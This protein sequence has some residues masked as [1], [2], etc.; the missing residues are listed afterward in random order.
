LD[1]VESLPNR[2]GTIVTPGLPQIFQQASQMR[3]EIHTHVRD[4]AKASEHTRQL[5]ARI[6]SLEE[7]L[8]QATELAIEAQ[9]AVEFVANSEKGST[10]PESVDDADALRKAKVTLRLQDAKIHGLEAMARKASA[11]CEALEREKAEWLRERA[12]M[13]KRVAEMEARMLESVADAKGESE[14][15]GANSTNQEHGSTEPTLTVEE[16]AYSGESAERALASTPATTTSAAM[17]PISTQSRSWASSPLSVDTSNM[18]FKGS[19]KLSPEGDSMPARYNPPAVPS[20][21][22]AAW[23]R[24]SFSDIVGKGHATAPVPVSDAP[25][26]AE[27]ASTPEVLSD[28]CRQ[29]NGARQLSDKL[30][31]SIDLIRKRP[32]ATSNTTSSPMLSSVHEYEGNSVNPGAPTNTLTGVSSSRALPKA[33]QYPKVGAGVVFQ[34]GNKLLVNF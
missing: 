23:T 13:T 22:K 1:L 30:K 33:P 24:G 26:T 5:Q 9:E 28:M 6:K 11:K 34:D 14:R 3:D 7:Q 27:Q 17:T 31:A 21:S 15:Q 29:I 19:R 18:S 4:A 12:E 2:E 8:E 10:Q 20:R 25:C 32:T 16:H